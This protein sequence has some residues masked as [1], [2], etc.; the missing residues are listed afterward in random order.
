MLVNFLVQKESSC[1][2]NTS[3]TFIF[4]FKEPACGQLFPDL[5]PSSTLGL[6]ADKK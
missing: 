1:T 3:I 6:Y 4:C 5:V 2:T